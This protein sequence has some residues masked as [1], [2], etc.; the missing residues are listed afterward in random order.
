MEE[1]EMGPGQGGPLGQSQGKAMW[2]S[3]RREGS[4]VTQ[5]LG[6]SAEPGSVCGVTHCCSDGNKGH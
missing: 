3:R 6:Q 4:I 2:S 1:Q 5:S